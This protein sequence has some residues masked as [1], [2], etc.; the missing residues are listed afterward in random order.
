L[1]ERALDLP[2][3]GAE[4]GPRRPAA[5]VPPEVAFATKLVRARR[6]I[7]RALDQGVAARWLTADAVD[8]SDYPV[9]SALDNRG[10]G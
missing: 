1:L 4:D 10:R 9:R 5:G 8:G 3:D 6:R 7:E 2:K